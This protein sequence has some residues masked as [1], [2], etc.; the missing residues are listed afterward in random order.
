MKV[1]SNCKVLTIDEEM[2]YGDYIVVDNGSIIEVGKGNIKPEYV[3][4]KQIDLNGCAV[5][6]GFWESHLHVVTGVRSLMEINLKDCSY[7][8]MRD[9]IKSH[10]KKVPS[11]DWTGGCDCIRHHPPVEF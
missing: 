5:I 9:R 3:R 2:P 8:Q 11:G 10:C 6:P 1:F 4:E 7:K